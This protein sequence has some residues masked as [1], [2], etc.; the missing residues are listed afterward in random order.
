MD[1]Q[2]PE[3]K[4]SASGQRSSAGDS[5]ASGKNPPPKDKDKKKRYTSGTKRA[6]QIEGGISKAAD[7]VTWAVSQGVQ[8]YRD[9]RKKSSERHKDGAVVE[10]YV[11]IAEG[12]SEGLQDASPA[13]TD[14][15]RAINSKRTRKALRGL[16]KTITMSR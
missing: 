10:S 11:N 5:K 9:R 13:L 7:R 6:Q 3:P 8:E 16:M 12:V 4:S 1:S 14:V 2:T 15:A